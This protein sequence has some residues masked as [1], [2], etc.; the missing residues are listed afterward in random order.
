MLPYCVIELAGATFIET[1][2]T[3]V[4]V[5]V[6]WLVIF[7]NVAIIEVLPPESDVANPWV[8]EALLIVAIEGSEELHV[9]EEVRSW[10]EVSEKVPVAL[11]CW[12][13]PLITVGFLGVISSETR[14]IPVT[15][16]EVAPEILPETAVIVVVPAESAL[17]VP[18]SEASLPMVATETS[19]EFQVT[20]EVISWVELSV[21]VPVA[22]NG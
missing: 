19:E 9:T 6:V 4:T 22:L 5:I 2:V 8:P 3:V 17:A 21:K 18:L 13:I 12:V 11:N 20:D 10:V 15:V 16:R 14:E 1:R 7:P